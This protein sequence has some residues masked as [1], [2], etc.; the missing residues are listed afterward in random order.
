LTVTLVSSDLVDSLRKLFEDLANAPADTNA[1]GKKWADAYGSYAGQASGLGT[2]VVPAGV[3]AATTLLGTQLGSAFKAGRDAGSS[4][5]ATATLAMDTA[6]VAFWMTPPQAFSGGALVA[7]A[8][9]M[10]LATPLGGAFAA[11]V[12]SPQP[13][14]AAQASKIGA[15]LDTWTKTVAVAMVSPPAS[16]MVS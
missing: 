8:L 4:G 16:G 11:G 15:I 13:T 6:F 5:L 1:A 7:L 9:P 14:A 10:M 3:Q 2:P 12:T